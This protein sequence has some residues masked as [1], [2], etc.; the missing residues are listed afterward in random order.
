MLVELPELCQRCFSADFSTEAFTF[1]LFCLPFE[2]FSFGIHCRQLWALGL[3]LVEFFLSASFSLPRFSVQFFSVSVTHH[4]GCFLPFRESFV[5]CVSLRLR[6]FDTMSEPDLSYLK[7]LCCLLFCFLAGFCRLNIT[8]RWSLPCG[9]SISALSHGAILG[10]TRA[11]SVVLSVSPCRHPRRVGIGVV[12][13][14]K[15]TSPKA[16][17]RAFRWGLL[18]VDPTCFTWHWTRH[19]FEL[20]PQGHLLFVSEVPTRRPRKYRLSSSCV[21]HLES[22]VSAVSL[23]ENGESAIKKTQKT[24]NNNNNKEKKKGR[25]C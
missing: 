10:E 11:R 18:P 5:L 17:P 13:G 25:I 20:C 16:S 3:G 6:S 4:G 15:M 7:G 2:L 8:G 23:L 21:L 24:N 1:R 22:H 14:L 19:T 9:V 12:A